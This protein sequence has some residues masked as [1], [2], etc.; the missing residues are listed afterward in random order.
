MS[1]LVGADERSRPLGKKRMFHWMKSI[2]VVRT[3]DVE[4]RSGNV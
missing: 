4:S 3:G 2:V 1:G